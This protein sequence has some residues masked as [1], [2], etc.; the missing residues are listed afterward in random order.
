MET[1]GGE[2]T[3]FQ[4]RIDGSVDFCFNWNDYVHG[5]GNTSGD[6]Q[7]GLCKL[8]CLSN[9]SASTKLQVDMRDKNSSSVYASYSTFYTDGSTTDYTLHICRYSG[10]AGDSLT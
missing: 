8:H 3:V 4:R 2:W 10:T 1:D 7:L 6:Y 5:F 9:G